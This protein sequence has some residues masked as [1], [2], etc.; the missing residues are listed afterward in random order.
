MPWREAMNTRRFPEMCTGGMRIA[1]ARCCMI[2]RTGVRIFRMFTQDG[3]QTQIAAIKTKEE[4]DE[5]YLFP[6]DVFEVV[7][8]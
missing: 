6:P 4:L 2:L 7:E 5:D 8:Q 1:A 3:G